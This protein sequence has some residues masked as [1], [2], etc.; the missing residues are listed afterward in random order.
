M[1][2]YSTDYAQVDPV[3]L[4][5]GLFKSLSR[6]RQSPPVTISRDFGGC[7]YSLMSPTALDDVALKILLVICALAG[8][9]ATS[10]KPS[11]PGKLWERLALSGDASGPCAVWQGS[12]GDVLREADMQSGGNNKQRVLDRLQG[13]S[14]VRIAKT[15]PDRASRWESNIISFSENR[16]KGEIRV[17]F[18]PG[19]SARI[20]REEHV[21]YSHVRLDPIRETDSPAARILHA[22]LSSRIRV[23]ATARY[24]LEKLSNIVYLPSEKPDDIRKRRSSILTAMRDLAHA[25]WEFRQAPSAAREVFEIRHTPQRPQ[26]KPMS[27]AFSQVMLPKVTFGRIP[28]QRTANDPR[29]MLCSPP[30]PMLL[31]STSPSWAP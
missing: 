11:A 6:N 31:R 20:L 9:S 21:Q 25:G 10:E 27:P 1:R 16:Q 18:S 26:P 4:E 5:F 13:L 3:L 22:V 23:G 30:H 14:A 7:S 12:I 29:G 8:T 24:S 19:L 15:G 17:A 28:A 2:P